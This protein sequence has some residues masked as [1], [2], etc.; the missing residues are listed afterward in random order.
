MMKAKARRVSTLKRAAIIDAA[1]LPA[2][3]RWSS[4]PAG[5]PRE[6][7]WGFYPLVARNFLS[8]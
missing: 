6:R 7:G 1:R 8:A 2:L 5:K 3:K 4:N